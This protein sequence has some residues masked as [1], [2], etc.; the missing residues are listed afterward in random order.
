MSGIAYGWG[1]EPLRLLARPKRLLG[2]VAILGS[3]VLGLMAF[4][5]APEGSVPAATALLAGTVAL[6]LA[7]M[8]RKGVG[9]WLF[10]AASWA[11]FVVAYGAMPAL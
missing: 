9:G 7:A 8:A 6:S 10:L 11:L 1:M 4:G 5:K 2:I 3:V